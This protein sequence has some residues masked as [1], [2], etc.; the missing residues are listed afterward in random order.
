[1]DILVPDGVTD[2]AVIEIML[3][4]GA[5]VEAEK[6]TA[7]VPRLRP[8]CSKSASRMVIAFRVAALLASSRSVMML[9]S[10]KTVQTKICKIM[11]KIAASWFC[12]YNLGESICLKNK[13]F[14]EWLDQMV[15]NVMKKMGSKEAISSEDML[16]M[17]LK[18]QSNHFSHLDTDLRSEMKNLRE[19][20]NKHF[21][22][23]REDMNRRFEE[24]RED[25]NRR[26]AES[27]E[28][29]NRRFEAV[30]KRFESV[31]KRFVSTQWLIGIGI[32]LMGVLMSLYQFLQ[33]PP[34]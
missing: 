6:T 11:Q 9:Q 3:E 4:F 23:V 5:V 28:D 30:D 29:M 25:M 22:E 16:I 24:S 26:F 8:S 17:V 34:A 27:R 33:P 10:Q 13:Y 12:S 32:T 19:D 31:D 7:E 2:A 18:S 20:T 14:E 1:M 21:E 15:D